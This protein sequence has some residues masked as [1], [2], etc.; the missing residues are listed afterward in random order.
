[1]ICMADYQIS[2]DITEHAEKPAA[3]DRPVKI[4]HVVLNSPDREA[5]SSQFIDLLGFKLSDRTGYMDFIRCS[6]DHHDRLYDDR[7]PDL[8]H[9]AFEMPSHNALMY[10]AG[11][12][13]Q[14]GYPTEWGS[15]VMD[16]RKQHLRLF[17][18]SQRVC[19]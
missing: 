6:S 7:Q 17:R 2:S 1:M 18:R 8:N 16:K 5:Q 11:R 14:T 15:G 10:G 13:K 9:V 19:H 4:S 12:M 3:K